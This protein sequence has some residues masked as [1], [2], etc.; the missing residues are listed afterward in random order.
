MSS[1]LSYTSNSL[2]KYFL[3]SSLSTFFFGSLVSE[4][5]LKF[6]EAKYLTGT[7]EKTLPCVTSA[8][9]ELVLAADE[10]KGSGVCR[11][12]SAEEDN[13]DVPEDAL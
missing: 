12:G 9:P 11:I 8:Y 6:I 13:V 2:L 7:V 3:T 1:M 5:C 10:R 4:K